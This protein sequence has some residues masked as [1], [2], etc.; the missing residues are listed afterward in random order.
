[1]ELANKNYIEFIESKKRLE[2]NHVKYKR[3]IKIIKF[4]KFIQSIEVVQRLL[5]NKK[6][7]YTININ[8]STYL[9]RY[10]IN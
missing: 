4:I 2:Y 8:K 10:K 7:L 9:Y 6:S 3:K 5:T 1:V